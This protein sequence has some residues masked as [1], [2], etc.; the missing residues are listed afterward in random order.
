MT[1]TSTVCVYDP[2]ICC[3]SG[4]CG[5]SVDSHLLQVTWDPRRFEVEGVRVTPGILAHG[6]DR[7]IWLGDQCEPREKWDKAS[8]AGGA[9]PPGI[10]LHP[11][12]EAAIGIPHPTG[13]MI[14]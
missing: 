11:A 14:P 2:A 9:Y 3:S 5:P 13:S 6:R 7:T 4:L 10:A 8:P 12:G 1:I